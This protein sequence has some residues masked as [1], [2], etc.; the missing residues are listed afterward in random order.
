MVERITAY[1]RMIKFSHSVFAL[2]F[3]FTSAIIAA[4]GIPELRKIFWITV[5]MVSGRSAAM[6]MNRLI[7]RRIDAENPRT[8]DREIPAGKVSVREAVVFVVISSLIFIF[9]AFMLNRLCLILSPVALAVFF[10]YPYTKRFTHLSHVF[11]G[12]AISGAT[13]G[14]WIAIEG[15]IDPRILIL[16]GGVIFWLSGFDI[17]YALQD[18]EFDR[19]AGLHSIP[20]RYGPRKSLLLSRLFHFATWLLLALTGLVFD[21]GYIYFGGLLVVGMLLLY[22]HRLVKED[23]LSQLDMAFFNMNG[24]ISLTVFFAT[25]FDYLVS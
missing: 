12:L 1:L 9:S 5:A 4:G 17:L 24:Y 11:L 22:E 16:T 19:K 7:D 8:R 25:L 10:I 18:M 23:D 13:V 6:G 15:K 2:P 20:G 3:A 14:A 21:L